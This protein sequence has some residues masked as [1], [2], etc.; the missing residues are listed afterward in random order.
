MGLLKEA[1]IRHLYRYV[2][3]VVGWGSGACGEAADESDPR[4]RPDRHGLLQ[5]RSL[6]GI[7]DEKYSG[8]G[9]PDCSTINCRCFAAN[10]SAGIDILSGCESDFG[11]APG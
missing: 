1:I 5:C 2:H 6:V 10:R 3:N 7:G 11:H 4:W 9:I 8:E